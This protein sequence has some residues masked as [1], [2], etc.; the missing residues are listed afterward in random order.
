MFG[1]LLSRLYEYIYINIYIHVFLNAIVHIYIISIYVHVKVNYPG[2]PFRC[3]IG[4]AHHSSDRLQG[5]P[6]SVL[7]REIC[8]VEVVRIHWEWISKKKSQ[9]EKTEISLVGG[10]V[11]WKRR[12][13]R[14]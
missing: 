13:Q 12:F 1:N 9:N 5:S 2:S 4:E 10:K 3:P 14:D 8:D 11:S 7:S 6:S